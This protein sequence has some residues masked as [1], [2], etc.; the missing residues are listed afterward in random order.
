LRRYIKGEL[1]TTKADFAKERLV[2]QEVADGAMELE[3]E[4]TRRAV[5][6]AAGHGGAESSAITQA[7][8]TIRDLT[9]ALRALS[10]H[11]ADAA[12]RRLVT[13]GVVPGGPDGAAMAKEEQASAARRSTVAG[14]ALR[15]IT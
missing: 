6:A 4:R 7:H 12:A 2:L 9:T 11:A 1:V 8:E 14:W 3:R 13:L 5:A 15:T 10:H